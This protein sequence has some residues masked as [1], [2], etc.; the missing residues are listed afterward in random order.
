M[1]KTTVDKISDILKSSFLE[2]ETLSKIYKSL[3]S[4]SKALPER[5]ELQYLIPDNNLKC[6][7]QAEIF[8]KTRVPYESTSFAFY[9]AMASGKT[10][11]A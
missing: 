8:R 2:N 3:K 7:Y 10:T 4:L 9:E 6:C 5:I 1:R 11:E